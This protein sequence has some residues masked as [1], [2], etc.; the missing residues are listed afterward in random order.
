MK[1]SKVFV[2]FGL[3]LLFGL[4]AC[5]GGD[6]DTNTSEAN[7]TQAVVIFGGAEAGKW[8]DEVV[9]QLDAVTNTVTLFEA[10]AE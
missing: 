7:D 4:A 6:A 5:G 8:N 2:L 1:F 3:V 9:A 10:V